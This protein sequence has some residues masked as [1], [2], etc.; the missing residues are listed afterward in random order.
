MNDEF[1]STEMYLQYLKYKATWRK[2]YPNK[3]IMSYA[4][5]AYRNFFWWA[6]SNPVTYSLR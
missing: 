1:N 5:W 4:D 3:R 6:D 2:F